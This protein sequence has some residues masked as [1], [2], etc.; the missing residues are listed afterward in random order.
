MPDSSGADEGRVVH[1]EPAPSFGDW[2]GKVLDLS[3]VFEFEKRLFQ[4]RETAPPEAWKAML[5]AA[6]KWAAIE[7]G[8]IESLYDT[9]RG[10]TY[11][12]AASVASWAGIAHTKGVE[13][14]RAI[15]DQLAA[16]E[17][18][19]DAATS[20]TEVS[21]YWIRSLHE[22]VCQSQPTYRVWTTVGWQ[23]RE[24]TLGAYKEYPNSPS[25]AD[26]SVIHYYAPPIDVP[27]E[28][29][30]LVEQLRSPEFVSASPV[31]QAAYAHY[32]FVQIHPFADGNGRVSRALASIF[33]YRAYGIPLVIFT[34]QKHRYFDALKGADGG[35][36]EDFSE[37]IRDAVVDT[38]NLVV[39]NMRRVTRPD[40]GA[41]MA[42][43]MV[44]QKGRGG[45]STK[46]LEEI[47]L[48]VLQLVSETLTDVV[49]L[50][51]MPNG[52]SV[53]SDMHI[54][55]APTDDRYRQI[56]FQGRVLVLQSS[57]PAYALSARAF[58]VAIGKP[59]VGGADIIIYDETG[60]TIFP[61]FLH[62]VHPVI[63][64]QIRLRARA[65]VE[66][67]WSSTVDTLI[68]RVKAAL[69]GEATV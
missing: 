66:T 16:Y 24:L 64:E 14:S 68:S 34:D 47:G 25:D 61:V 32:A 4:A 38:I 13:A 63:T 19:L 20:Q 28:M 22:A 39:E 48:R 53:T 33:L 35:K 69:S 45:L 62:E 60:G 15:T 23:D 7:T 56:A 29:R 55:A 8:A 11:S 36:F 12:V 40:V 49:E 65:V 17:W 3:L 27:V 59:N 44:L 37:F 58:F 67:E 46:E 43:L 21:E 54:E 57:E 52:V 50:T 9:D 10:Y 6:N 5:D 31:M 1:Y 51:S 41:R 18:V 30:R 2:A 26:A 42:E